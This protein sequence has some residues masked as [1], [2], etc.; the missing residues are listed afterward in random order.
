MASFSTALR[1]SSARRRTCAGGSTAYSWSA[2]VQRGKFVD[3]AITN[4]VTDQETDALMVR[5]S[6]SPHHFRLI[7][8]SI[9]HQSVRRYAEEL[10]G[11]SSRTLETSAQLRLRRPMS[12][13][14]SLTVAHPNYI[15]VTFLFLSLSLL[16]LMGCWRRKTRDYHV[17]PPADM[18][19]SDSNT[20]SLL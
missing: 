14:M 17:V 7:K 13:P 16:L 9:F 19:H 18:G 10:S 3:Y 5:C 4:S 8:N 11:G 6:Q 12:E 2:S 1:C 15:S 20:E